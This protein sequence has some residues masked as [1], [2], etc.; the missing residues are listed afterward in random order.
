M[1]TLQERHEEVIQT[2]EV[3][4]DL[5]A[6]IIEEIVLTAE[7]AFLTAIDEHAIFPIGAYTNAASEGLQP[8]YAIE[9]VTGTGIARHLAEEGDDIVF[10]GKDKDYAIVE[11]LRP[12]GAAKFDKDFK[13]G[14]AEA[15]RAIQSIS[16][17][18]SRAWIQNQLINFDEFPTQRA[19]VDIYTPTDG[20]VVYDA[21]KV[22]I[23]AFLNQDNINANQIIMGRDTIS[24]LTDLYFNDATDT[25]VFDKL[26]ST[27]S[28]LDFIER[29]GL[30]NKG[31]F[32][33]HD[34]TSG[35]I[36]S[37]EMPFATKAINTSNGFAEAIGGRHAAIGVVFPN[38]NEVLVVEVTA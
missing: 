20:R 34:T 14:K 37:L 17:A 26:K 5:G 33:V 9:Y 24:R 32:I 3:A 31:M 36:S 12:A 16:N 27:Y 1:S 19:D 7:E 15:S 35:N 30:N 6:E 2:L 25:T 4:T 21:L 38:P 10:F 29:R 8:T 23:D 18:N 22:A 28:S 11:P 13:T